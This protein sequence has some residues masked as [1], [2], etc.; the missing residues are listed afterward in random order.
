MRG[1]LLVLQNI[2]VSTWVI[3]GWY[4]KRSLFSK[5]LGCYF[6][7]IYF[8]TCGKL[9][10]RSR[11]RLPSIAGAV[12]SEIRI[13]LRF[14]PVFFVCKLCCVYAVLFRVLSMQWAYVG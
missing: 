11:G 12:V 8:F 2:F 6:R 4:L 13:Y 7:L 1:G 5:S 14:M 3:F 10:V 9:L